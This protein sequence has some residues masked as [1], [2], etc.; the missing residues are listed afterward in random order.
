LL[1]GALALLN[2]EC[3]NYWVLDCAGGEHVFFV[4]HDPLVVVDQFPGV[5]EFVTALASRELADRNV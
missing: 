4:C 5:R 1:P 3:D 2:E